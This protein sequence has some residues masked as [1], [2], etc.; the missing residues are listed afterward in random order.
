MHP[1]TI[2]YSDDDA[3]IKP[4]LTGTGWEYVEGEIKDEGLPD[5][6]AG[7]TTPQSW[8]PKGAG[9]EVYKTLDDMFIACP[10]EDV[11]EKIA[12]WSTY[13]AAI[14]PV[15]KKTTGANR[16]SFTPCESGV[17]G[18][19][20]R[21]GDADASEDFQSNPITKWHVLMV[22]GCLLRGED[23]QCCNTIRIHS[24]ATPSVHTML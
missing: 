14:Q 23:T 4:N 15:L 1:P 2:F 24:A 13:Y 9:A 21:C 17:D 18:Q 8:G 10:P 20:F 6:T 12:D 3:E 16:V 7:G 19:V 11:L 5:V 22:M